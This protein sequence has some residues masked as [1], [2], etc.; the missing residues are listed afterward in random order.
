MSEAAFELHPSRLWTAPPG[1]K[2]TLD[3]NDLPGVGVPFR[4]GEAHRLPKSA[5]HVSVTWGQV[6]PGHRKKVRCPNDIWLDL[7]LGEGRWRVPA[8]GSPT[9]KDLGDRLD[10]V[11][12]IGRQAGAERM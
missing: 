5:G 3:L 1:V 11:T 10:L 9:L 8:G 4:R 2:K 12:G 7:A 6:K